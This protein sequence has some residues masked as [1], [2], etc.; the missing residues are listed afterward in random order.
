MYATRFVAAIPLLLSFAGCAGMQAPLPV[1]PTIADV[2]ATQSQLASISDPQAFFRA[3]AAQIIANCGSYFDQLVAIA[4]RNAQNAGQVTAATQAL[5]A[6]LGLAQAAPGPISIVGVV[7]PAIAGSIAQAQ[8][9]SPGGDHPAAMGTLVAAQM[10]VYLAAI[11]NPPTD[12]PTAWMA[13][14]GLF[15]TCSPAGIEAAKQQ[16]LADAPNHL[17]VPGMS[18]PPLAPAV[19][20]PR[21]ALMF[22]RP[23]PPLPPPF[24]PPFAPRAPW[25]GI[26]QVMIRTAPAPFAALTIVAQ[27]PPDAKT[28]KQLSNEHALIQRFGRNRVEGGPRSLPASIVPRFHPVAPTPIAPPAEPVAKPDPPREN[29]IHPDD[30]IASAPIPPAPPAVVPTVKRK[31]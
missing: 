31:L 28:R 23:P 20:A 11:G 13:L 8:A 26:P 5:S 18:A 12:A 16:A 2:A 25:M 15:R 19:F 1:M 21:A 22:A 30:P 27:G 7:G 4:Q 24:P 14:Y 6:I 10:N 3:G 9:G 17:F 29:S